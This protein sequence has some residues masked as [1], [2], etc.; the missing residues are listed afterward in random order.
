MLNVLQL[1]PITCCYPH[2]TPNKFASGKADLELVD[3]CKRDA[4]GMLAEVVSMSARVW[5]LDAS[6]DSTLEAIGTILAGSS[7]D[8]MFAAPCRDMEKCE[9]SGIAEQ[10]PYDALVKIVESQQAMK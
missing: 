4:I 2:C 7:A 10:A 9:A 1:Y 5:P 6:L 8:E 3:G